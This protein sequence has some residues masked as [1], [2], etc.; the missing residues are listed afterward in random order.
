VIILITKTHD[1][2]IETVLRWAESLGYRVVEHNTGN[3]T[4]P[5]AIIANQFGETVVVEV[6]TGANFRKLLKKP[7]LN[8][9]LSISPD[10]FLGIIVVGDRIEHLK[11]H[12]IEVGLPEELFESGSKRQKVFGVGTLDFK[13]IIPPLLVSILGARASAIGRI[14]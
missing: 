3:K 11:E 9:P 13:E 7:R 5:D 8:R 2:I 4:G 1:N 14:R 10:D 12:G 6:E